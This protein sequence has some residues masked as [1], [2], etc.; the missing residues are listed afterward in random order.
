MRT[1]LIKNGR[2]EREFFAMHSKPIS[3]MRTSLIKNSREKREFL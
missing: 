2:E 3:L 1:S